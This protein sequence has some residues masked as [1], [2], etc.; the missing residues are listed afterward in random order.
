MSYAVFMFFSGWLAERVNLRYF[1]AL[2]MIFSGLF[3]YLFGLAYYYDIHSYYFFV[4][5]QIITGAFQ[6]TGW[7]ACVAAV[8]NWFGH[9]SKR[10]VIMGIWNSHTNVGNS[11]GTAIAGAFVQT[12]WGLSFMVPGLFIA[13]SGFILFLFLVPC[14]F[15]RFLGSQFDQN[16][17]ILF[18]FIR[19]S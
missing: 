17:H 9:S 13:V 8:G 7:P 12:N 16:I 19:R 5:I 14:K 4:I 2:G 10:G 3:T 18:F 11:L 1:L 15:L 6:S